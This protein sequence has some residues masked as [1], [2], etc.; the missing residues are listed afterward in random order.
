LLVPLITLL[1]VYAT[2][3]PISGHLAAY[4]SVIWLDFWLAE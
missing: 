2:E 4:R 3:N 1:F